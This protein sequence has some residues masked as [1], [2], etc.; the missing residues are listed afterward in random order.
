MDFRKEIRGGDRKVPSSREKRRE[1]GIEEREEKGQ[2]ERIDR[3]EGNWR[4]WDGKARECKKTSPTRLP[5]KGIQIPKGAP[6]VHGE[7]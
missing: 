3:I 4:E 7:E 2:K 6:C 1:A 5:V